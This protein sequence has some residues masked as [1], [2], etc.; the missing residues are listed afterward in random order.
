MRD[1]EGFAW[2]TLRDDQRMIDARP[3]EQT[4]VRAGFVECD[5]EATRRRVWELAET[6][7]QRVI[8]SGL[9]NLRWLNGTESA[10]LAAW[11]GALQANGF[12]AGFARREGGAIIVQVW[13][14]APNFVRAVRDRLGLTGEAFAAAINEAAPGARVTKQAVWR[15]EHG[16]RSPSPAMAAIIRQLGE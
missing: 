5:S 3:S 16:E 1:P 9:K 4:L 12:D 11:I 6:S 8:A 2:D 13:S 14:A 15:W 10:E 7:E